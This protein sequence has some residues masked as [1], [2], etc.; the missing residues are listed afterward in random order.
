MIPS[1]T[2]IIPMAAAALMMFS[3][4]VLYSAEEK[5]P[6]VAAGEPKPAPTPSP[7]LKST[8]PAKKVEKSPVE[9]V[10]DPLKSAADKSNY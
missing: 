7:K 10:A 9:P 1:K 3:T 5:L 2:L 8:A 6:E 4:P